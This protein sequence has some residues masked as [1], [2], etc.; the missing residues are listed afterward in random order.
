MENTHVTPYT[1]LIAFEGSGKPIDG[2]AG[3]VQSRADGAIIAGAGLDVPC[4]TASFRSVVASTAAGNWEAGRVDFPDIDSW[5][6]VDTP[7]A[8]SA[9]DKP[10]GSSAGTITW[11]VLGGGGRFQGATGLVTGNFTGSAD[12]AFVDHQVFKLFL[13]P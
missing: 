9:Q 4:A 13:V 10:D 1:M 5:L 3:F 8:G 2:A 7:A 12:G 11:R 6:E